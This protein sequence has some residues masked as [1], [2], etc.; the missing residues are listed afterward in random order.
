MADTISD[1]RL[2]MTD[3]QWAQWQAYT[4]GFGE[5]DASGVDVSLIRQNLRLPFW[6]RLEKL[7]REFAFFKAEYMDQSNDFQQAIEALNAVG[8]RFVIIGVIAMR[9]QGAA[10]MT[11]DID[12]AFARDTQNLI[13]LVQALTPYHPCLRGAPP[14]LPFFWD[15]RTLQ[16]SINLTLETDIGSIDLLGDPPGIASFEDLWQRATIQTRNGVE[17]RVASVEDLIAM[18]Q[19]AGRPKDQAHLLELERIQQIRRNEPSSQV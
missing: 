2:G 5:Q 12:F 9:L 19:A 4:H 14:G 1:E 17:V 16:T 6:A 8:F 10:H 18:K 11:D 13:F 3:A 7:E 15:V